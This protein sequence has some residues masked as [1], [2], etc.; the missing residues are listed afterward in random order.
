MQEKD[1]Y[2]YE[3]LHSNSFIKLNSSSESLVKAYKNL[4]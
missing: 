2:F 3:S 1:R 4:A